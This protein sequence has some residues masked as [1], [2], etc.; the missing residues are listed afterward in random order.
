MEETRTYKA[1]LEELAASTKTLRADVYTLPL[2]LAVAN[3]AF[4]APAF[5]LI[6]SLLFLDGAAKLAVFI[7]AI[8][9]IIII[10]AYNITLR[11]RA[12]AYTQY[13]YKETSGIWVFQIFSK[14]WG[15]Y[16]YKDTVLSYSSQKLTKQQTPKNAHLLPLAFV[17][18]DI[19]SKTQADNTVKYCG[20]LPK[21]GKSVKYTLTVKDGVPWAATVGGARIKYFD[22]ND[23]NIFFDI[24]F[25]LWDALKAAKAKLPA[26]ARLRR[27]EK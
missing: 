6:I 17:D 26:T 24:P 18:A 16:V 27:A 7:V 3:I 10:V 12:T 15:E 1:E 2:W 19:H 13:V 4:T 5:A 23:T 22:Y 21:K 14:T 20:T 25:R 9:L 11:V 8:S